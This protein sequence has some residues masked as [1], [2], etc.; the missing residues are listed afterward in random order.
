MKR[1]LLWIAAYAVAAALLAAVV[2]VLVLRS[3]WFRG[4][5]RDWLVGSI[6]TATGGRA[7]I[8]AFRFDWA[9]L[10]A[11]AD[12]VVLHGTEP[13]GKPPLFRAGSIAVGLKIVSLVKRNIDIRSLDVEAP[14]IAL[15]IDANGRTKACAATPRRRFSSSR[16][17]VSAFNTASFRWNR[18]PACHLR[19]TAGT[20]RRRSPLTT[21]VRATG[22]TS[23]SSLSSLRL[24]A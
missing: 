1:R 2:G 22:A 18:I 14:R 19:R 8:G 6:E 16:S 7:E 5:A 13:A 23:A 12:S 21:P 9:D 17:A 4:K 24:P 20:Y 10:R 11:E 3:E 15:I